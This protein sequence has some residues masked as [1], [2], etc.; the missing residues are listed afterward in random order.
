MPSPPPST[1]RENDFVTFHLI[2][3]ELSRLTATH[4]GTRKDL[5]VVPMQHDTRR[6]GPIRRRGPGLEAR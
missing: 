3:R 4:L 5:V 6:D 2:P 1:R